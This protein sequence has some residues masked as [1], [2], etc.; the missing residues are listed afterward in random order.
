MIDGANGV[1]YVGGGEFM[2]GG[3]LGGARLA[4]IEGSAFIKER[5]TSG[6]VDGAI[7]CIGFSQSDNVKLSVR[8]HHTSS[9]KQGSICCIDNRGRC[10]RC[11]GSTN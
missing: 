9:T 7:L 5:G 2:G 11:N 8:A 3:Y 1:N 10:E 6:S 4:A